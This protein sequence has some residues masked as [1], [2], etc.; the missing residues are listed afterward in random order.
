MHLIWVALLFKLCWLLAT[1]NT[2][3]KRNSITSS[4]CHSSSQTRSYCT[5]Q[6]VVHF[7]RNPNLHQHVHERRILY[8][9]AFA[10]SLQQ[11]WSYMAS[12]SWMLM[13]L[14]Y[15]ITILQNFFT[16]ASVQITYLIW[17]KLLEFCMQW[18]CK[19]FTW[20][21]LPTCSSTTC[22]W[23]C[24][25]LTW[26]STRVTKRNCLWHHS[27]SLSWMLSGLFRIVL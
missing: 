14:K 18:C 25:S 10:F 19:N 5:D 24:I 9:I 17:L 15:I 7:L 2:L 13:R 16:L 1:V 21:T 27:H 22:C 26:F 23:G 3:H 4:K 11:I 12:R 20:I 6:E 8:G